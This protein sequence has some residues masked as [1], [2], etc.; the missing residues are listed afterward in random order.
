MIVG[1]NFFLTIFLL[2]LSHLQWRKGEIWWW[3]IFNW[4]E[5]LDGRRTDPPTATSSSSPE[6]HGAICRFLFFP[7]VSVLW[8]S[9]EAEA[10]R[11]YCPQQK[12]PIFFSFHFYFRV[13]M[14]ALF[15]K[16]KKEIEW[17]PVSKTTTI[18]KKAK[19]L[20]N[21]FW[22]G[23]LSIYLPGCWIFATARGWST[24]NSWSSTWCLSTWIRILP[25]TWNGAHHLVSELNASRFVQFFFS[26]SF[27]FYFILEIAFCVEKLISIEN[28]FFVFG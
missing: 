25:R 7:F 14:S 4:D 15:D 8:L 18:T 13:G 28:F 3:L 10:T 27:H 2:G 16:P 26:L 21:H 12:F 22:R 19:K 24:S 5:V 20:D 1:S 11:N 6:W 23:L 9:V 17:R